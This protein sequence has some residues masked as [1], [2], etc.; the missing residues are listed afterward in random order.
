M[1]AQ[2]QVFPSHSVSSWVRCRMA[3]FSVFNASISSSL[4]F[5][6]YVRSLGTPLLRL[7]SPHA[8][9]GVHFRGAPASLYGWRLSEKPVL[10]KEDSSRIEL[11]S[12]G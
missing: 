1:S 6:R 9:K 12:K 11:S 10:Y 4:L 2:N 8:H 7:A 3:S 5:K